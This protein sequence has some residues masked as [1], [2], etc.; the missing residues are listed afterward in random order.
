MNCPKCKNKMEGYCSDFVTSTGFPVGTGTM[1]RQYSYY[2]HNCDAEY[3]KEAHK[4]LRELD[5][6]DPP[7]DG[8]KPAS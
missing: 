8:P 4:E 5:S 3:V 2:C 6:G 1:A 7:A